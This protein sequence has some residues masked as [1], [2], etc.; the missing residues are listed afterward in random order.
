MCCILYTTRYIFPT[1]IQWTLEFPPWSALLGLI[2][3]CLI[4]HDSGQVISI[5]WSKLAWYS[6]HFYLICDGKRHST[7]SVRIL[8]FVFSDLS[9][10]NRFIWTY[11]R[12]WLSPPMNQF[13]T[14]REH[15]VCCYDILFGDEKQLGDLWWSESHNPDRPARVRIRNTI[16]QALDSLQRQTKRALIGW[17]AVSDKVLG[18]QCNP[19]VIRWNPESRAY[20]RNAP[21]RG[22][23]AKPNLA[24]AQ[25]LVTNFKFLSSSKDLI[26][27]FLAQN[28][29]AI[30]HAR[31]KIGVERHHHDC[32]DQAKW[33]AM[34][35]NL[36]PICSPA[37]SGIRQKNMNRP[38]KTITKTS[39]TRT[40]M[41]I[42]HVKW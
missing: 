12:M 5:A 32:L 28:Q 9:L 17:C 31:F 41:E 34:K 13:P 36:E 16:F 29:N 3:N 15:E 35:I 11:F 24:L 4:R 2:S 1:P 27:P 10:L 18:S 14:I 21:N 23:A 8:V 26:H 33:N 37:V 30:A 25:R 39:Y 22:F 42:T 20:I 19:F 7:P 40:S 38:K 6:F